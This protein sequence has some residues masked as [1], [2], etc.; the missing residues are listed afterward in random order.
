MSVTPASV[1]PGAIDGLLDLLRADPALTAIGLIVLDG[2]PVSPIA[3]PV[4]VLIVGGNGDEDDPEGA[5]SELTDSS[6]RRGDQAETID[7]RCHLEHW[8]GGDDVAACRNSAFAALTTIKAALRRDPRLGGS[9]TRARLA[10]RLNYAVAH[11]EGDTGV[12]L[13]FVVRCD[14]L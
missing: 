10:G 11:F 12:G 4:T 2:P 6:L 8:E 14:A 1:I 5:S 3:G 7:L 9:V 13:P